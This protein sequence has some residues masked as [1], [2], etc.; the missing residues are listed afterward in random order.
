[1]QFRR[2]SFPSSAVL[3]IMAILLYFFHGLNF[4]IDF[5]GG[6]LIEVQSKVGSADLAKMRTTLSG[7]NLGDVQLKQFGG[8]THVLIRVAQHPGGDAAQPAAITKV[9]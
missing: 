9:V 1:M 6:T 8:P 7:L 4:G 2:V 5:I 3:S